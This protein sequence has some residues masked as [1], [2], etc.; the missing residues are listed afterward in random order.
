MKPTPIGDDDGNNPLNPNPV[1]IGMRN[2][3]ELN[4]NVNIDAIPHI[5]DPINTNGMDHF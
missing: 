5:H 2:I 4:G 1:L 3:N